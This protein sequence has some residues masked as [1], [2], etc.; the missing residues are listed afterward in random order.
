MTTII[1]RQYEWGCEIGS[2]MQ[3]TNSDYRP[4]NGAGLVKQVER[5]GLIVACSGDAAICDLLMYGWKLPP[6]PKRTP[7]DLHPFMVTKAVPS[8][9]DAIHVAGFKRGKYEFSAL[10]GIR[11]QVFHIETDGSILTHQEGIY[12]IG[13]GSPYAVGALY[14]GASVADALEIAE[15]NDSYTSGPFTIHEQFFT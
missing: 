3:T 8:I 9:R 4:Y 1:A 5:G 15:A 10:L 2:D 12:G 6:L 14:A 7:T 11:G 13:S